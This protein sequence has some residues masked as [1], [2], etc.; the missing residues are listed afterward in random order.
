MQNS[1]G[2]VTE[3]WK[4]QD[5]ASVGLLSHYLDFDPVRK[6]LGACLLTWVVR[7]RAIVISVSLLAFAAGPTLSCSQS[8][9]HPRS[10]SPSYDLRQERSG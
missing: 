1:H 5:C 7:G 8:Q 4:L 6:D 9:L 3:Q 2:K 10:C